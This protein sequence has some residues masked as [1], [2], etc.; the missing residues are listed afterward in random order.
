MRRSHVDV[1]ARNVSPPVQSVADDYSGK[2]E[3]KVREVNKMTVKLAAA[4]SQPMP[5][6]KR[7]TRA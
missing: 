1:R 5:S 3:V 4:F 6:K 7:R 2:P